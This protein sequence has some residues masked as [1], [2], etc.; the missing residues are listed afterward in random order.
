MFLQVEEV[1]YCLESGVTVKYT[2]SPGSSVCSL[3]MSVI[4]YCGDNIEEPS[5]LAKEV[6]VRSDAFAVLRAEQSR[7]PGHIAHDWK[8]GPTQLIMSTTHVDVYVRPVHS[9]RWPI[10]YGTKREYD[11]NIINQDF[12]RALNNA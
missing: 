5:L 1:E 7:M 8:M 4:N 9:L 3:I 2:Y 12:E 10:F 11:N 6:F